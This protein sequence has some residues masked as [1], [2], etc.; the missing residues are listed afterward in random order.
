M[1]ATRGC[2]IFANDVRKAETKRKR[3]KSTGSE[4]RARFPLGDIRGR[5]VRERGFI[6][7]RITV[8]S[9]CELFVNK[10]LRMR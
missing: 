8:G 1:N 6:A 5:F 7:S 4:R 9:V 3:E 10:L 2:S